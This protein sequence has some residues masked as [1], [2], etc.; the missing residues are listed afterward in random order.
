MRPLDP[1]LLSHARATRAFMAGT[2]VVGLVLTGLIIAQAV[3]ITDVVVRVFQ[4]GASGGDV[5]SLLRALAVVVVARALVAW[6]SDYFAYRSSAAVKSQ[7][8]AAAFA[9]VSRWGPARLAT[10]NTGEFVHLTGRGLDALD[11]YFS[12]YLPQLVLAVLVPLALGV[13]ILVEDPVSALIV[14]L[15]VPLIPVFM[16]LIGRFTQR[17]VDRQWRTLG[18]LGGHFLDVVSGLGTLKAFR[19]EGHQ[20]EQLLSVNDRYRRTTMGVLRVS[21]LSSLV[22]ELLSSLSVALIAV[23]IGLRLLNGTLDLRTGLLV[24]VLAPEVYLPLR[25]VGMHFHAAAEGLGAAERVFDVIEREPP[26]AGT[27]AV[28]QGATIEF[29]HVTIRPD[30]D[31]PPALERFSEVLQARGI[32]ALVGPSGSGKTTILQTILGFHDVTRGEVRLGGVALAECDLEHWR[33]RVAYVPQTTH[34]FS[35]SLRDNVTLGLDAN[36]H[37]ILGA[38]RLAGLGND[39]LADAGLSL[40]AVIGEAGRGLSVGQRRRLGLARAFLR[41]QQS[42]VDWVLLD[43]PT[44][45]LDEATEQLVIDAM[46]HLA[47]TSGVLVVVHRSA[48][49]RVA[50]R[51]IEVSAAD[52]AAT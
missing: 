10:F 44:A 37:V 47:R 30:P 40:D 6:L 33:Q 38:L 9:S 36:D 35:A 42:V 28:P 13:T 41:Q 29:D 31:R 18:V 50:D 20:V 34:V 26:S 17:K 11:Q 39:V 27:T 24:L 14:A 51:V 8:R 48:V 2:V 22:L 15:T 52:R 43:E 32:T 16:I 21:F 3:I 49:R 25:L 1:R 7:L 23:G 5:G 12:R 45:S 19:R 46:R 4:Q